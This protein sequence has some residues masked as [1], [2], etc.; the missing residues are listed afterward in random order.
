[1]AAGVLGSQRYWICQELELQVVV[2]SLM[3]LLGIELSGTA[4][5]ALNY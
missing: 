3:E 2:S 5:H 1:M 4:L